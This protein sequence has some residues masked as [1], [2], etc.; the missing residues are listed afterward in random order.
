MTDEEQLWSL[1]KRSSARIGNLD[2][3]GAI[4]TAFFVA[5]GRVIT[6]RHVLE[7]LGDEN[8]G[9]C[10]WI[11]NGVEAKAEF[12]AEFGQENS[13]DVALLRLK[14][15]YA[16]HDCVCLTSG[17]EAG[18]ALLSIGFPGGQAEA[19]S[20]TFTFEFFTE[21]SNWFAIKLKQGVA[22]GGQSGSA[23]V[24]LRTKAVCGVLYSVDEE[25]AE[26]T[27]AVPIEFAL[28]TWPE[29]AT[30][31]ANYH[32]NNSEWAQLLPRTKLFRYIESTREVLSRAPM[33]LRSSR[34][35]SPLLALWEQF[36]RLEQ[37]PDFIRKVLKR[38]KENASLLPD[39]P[40]IKAQAEGIDLARDYDGILAQ[41]RQLPVDAWLKQTQTLRSQLFAERDA[42]RK[43]ER[44]QQP[45]DLDQRKLA[46][47][48]KLT[49]LKHFRNA[50]YSIKS[51]LNT[52][53]FQRC[54]LVMGSFG[55]GKTHFLASLLE[56]SQEPGEAIVFPA[57]LDDSSQQLA[58]SL[59]AQIRQATSGEW[60]SLGQFL[61]YLFPDGKGKFVIAIDDFHLNLKQK[62]RIS[63]DVQEAIRTG[64]AHKNLYWAITLDETKYY[65]VQSGESAKERESENKFWMEY[66]STRE[67]PRFDDDD[68]HEDAADT[69]SHV[70]SGAWL[71]LDFL[72]GADR[73]G[74]QLLQSLLEETSEPGLLGKTF[75]LAAPGQAPL[76]ETPWIAWVIWTSRSTLPDKSIVH[77]NYLE[78]VQE[79]WKG[80]KLHFDN[81]V[82][83]SAAYAAIRETAAFL[84]DFREAELP[85]DSLLG[86]LSSKTTAELPDAATALQAV[87]SLQANDL[88]RILDEASELDDAKSRIE[89]K[90]SFFWAWR[91]AERVVKDVSSVKFSSKDAV[92][93]FHQKLAQLLAHN[94]FGLDSDALATFL[95]LV[96]DLKASGNK[97]IS[98]LA[99]SAWSW[100]ERQLQFRATVWFALPR[101]DVGRQGEIVSGLRKH[102]P[103]IAD[104]EV[105]EIFAL[106]HLV[107]E[108][109]PEV[110]NYGERFHLLRPF[111]SAIGNSGL[112]DY[113][114]LTVRRC[115]RFAAKPD[116]VVSALLAFGGC[117]VLQKSEEIADEAYYALYRLLGEAPN[118]I[119]WMIR[120]LGQVAAE[121]V[122]EQKERYFYQ[123]MLAAF[124]RNFVADEGPA[125]FW[126][127]KEAQW[128]QA[129]RLKMP[130][131]MPKEM[132][133]EANFAF[134][135][136]YRT[137]SSLD[138]DGYLN[139]IS[140]LMASNGPSRHED[141]QAA[142][143]LI[144]HTSSTLG[145]N[146]VPVDRRFRD[147]LS[148]LR[149]DPT[150]ADINRKY[151]PFYDLN[152]RNQE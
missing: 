52:P 95:L 109:S 137:H 7:D 91:I 136:W 15:P 142:F 121:G 3:P 78:F 23:L 61:K 135:Y 101:A 144:R 62:P 102:V 149:K 45:M 97:Q 103:K 65:L 20:V 41:L 82:P 57:T 26:T 129:I 107:H 59:L 94:D 119:P 79:F 48:Q 66:G 108:I 18:D 152:L 71:S 100:L 140:Q 21:K 31:A 105:R 98:R 47:E 87:R 113:F 54:F 133:K 146:A 68:W 125:G 11:R 81:D 131:P 28:Q 4:G 116:E 148:E 130:Y 76:I 39:A 147:T 83:P 90:F 127:L 143:F 67:R 58:D 19:D 117:E 14:P 120:Y 2:Q 104:S 128:Y 51:E 122:P 46:L 9:V 43:P 37:W 49:E 64:A 55:S 74:S 35:P 17:I 112:A 36:L 53:S 73:I 44:A 151:A 60:S 29:I 1:L 40:A 145:Q 42:L 139:L 30:A 96:L 13:A 138:R 118:V 24:N 50:L 33:P 114:L 10:R 99:G 27:R 126:K 123:Y 75:A 72:N 5:P 69:S 84:A 89:L 93:S 85:L 141:H 22:R 38:T 70:A 111:Y 92:Q 115:L 12:T 34:I 106:L 16:E 86:R 25:H 63:R 150:L 124:C 6:A 32:K 80:Y 132:A 110:M 77:L 56:C 134:G 8:K 88:L